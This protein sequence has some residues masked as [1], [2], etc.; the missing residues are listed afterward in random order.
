[1]CGDM[2]HNLCLSFFAMSCHLAVFHAHSFS[3]NP[4]NDTIL[5]Q[6]GFGKNV[7]ESF[8]QQFFYRLVTN[9]DIL[10]SFLC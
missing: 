8:E 7:G 5:E 10:P 3:S 1:M 2:R 9:A 6:W 4:R